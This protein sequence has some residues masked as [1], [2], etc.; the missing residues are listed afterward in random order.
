M[1]RVTPF[2]KRFF[3]N[4]EISFLPARVSFYSPC[5]PAALS[6]LCTIDNPP[7]TRHYRTFTDL[8]ENFRTRQITRGH[9]SSALSPFLPPSLPSLE[10]KSKTGN[11]VTRFVQ[12]PSLSLS[13]SRFGNTRL[14]F[15]LADLEALL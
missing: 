9:P 1:G 15:T 5:S 7:R 10:R 11:R 6:D 12:F 2:R 13:F 8:V 4:D 14:T 3:E